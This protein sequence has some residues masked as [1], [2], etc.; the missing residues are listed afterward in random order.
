MAGFLR[1][2]DPGLNFS[3]VVQP[4]NMAGSPNVQ[5]PQNGQENNYFR[6]SGSEPVGTKRIFNKDTLSSINLLNVTSNKKKN[7]APKTDNRKLSNNFTAQVK[8]PVTLATPDR[9]GRKILLRPTGQKQRCILV[10]N[11]IARITASRKTL[12]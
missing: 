11:E 1:L 12:E 8:K 7:A 3:H 2:Y 10:V 5:P 4:Y 6:I 9:T